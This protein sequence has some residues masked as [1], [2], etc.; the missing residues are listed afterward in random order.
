M[1][2]K[3][4]LKG[5]SFEKRTY[6][7]VMKNVLNKSYIEKQETGWIEFFGQFGVSVITLVKG[8]NVLGNAPFCTL[9]ITNTAPSTE[10][11]KVLQIEPPTNNKICNYTK[12]QLFGPIFWAL[13]ETLPDNF[14]QLDLIIRLLPAFKRDLRPVALWKQSFCVQKEWQ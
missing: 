8:K 3:C 7:Q 13:S 11:V 1:R 12:S 5:S 14:I 10:Y 9:Y 2:V 6:N 4:Y